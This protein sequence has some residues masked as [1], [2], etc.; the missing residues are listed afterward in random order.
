MKNTKKVLSV[1]LAGALAFGSMGAAFAAAPA[2]VQGTDYETAVERLSALDILKGYED[3]TFQ[4]EKTI[5]RAEFAAV[6]VRSLGLDAS[7]KSSMGTT[8][9]NDV[10]SNHWASGY[11][12]IASGLKVINGK[13]EGVFDPEAPVKYEEAVTM[14]VR[15]LGYEPAAK[16]KGGYPNG[17]LVIAGQEDISDDVKGTIGASAPRGIVAQL[18]DNSLEVPMMVQVGYGDDAKFVQS[19]TDGTDEETLLADK[20][21]TEK[22]EEKVIDIP[23]TDS[24]LDDNEIRLDDKGVIEVPEGF[25]FEGVYNAKIKAFINDDD[26]LVSYEVDEDTDIFFDAVE[27]TSGDEEPVKLVAKDKEY[28]F[29]KDATIYENGKKVKEADLNAKYSYAKAVV[30]D[31]KITSLEAYDLDNMIVVEKVEKTHVLGY[32][33]DVNFDDYYVIKD[34]KSIELSDLEEGDIVFYNTSAEYAEVFNKTVKG[35]ID[36]VFGAGFRLNDEDYDIASDSMYVDEDELETIDSDILDEMKEADKEVTVYLDRQDE[37]RLVLGDRGEVKTSTV[38]ALLTDDIDVDTD[39]RGNHTLL[40]DVINNS[41]KEISYKVEAKDVEIDIVKKWATD[42][43]N[44]AAVE[45]IAAVGAGNQH[46]VGASTVDKAWDKYSSDEQEAITKHYFDV[47]NVYGKVGEV[48][49]TTNGAAATKAL[50]GTVIE[51]KVDEDGDVTELNLDLDDKA[52]TGNI[53]TDAKYAEGE[54]LEKSSL[55]FDA[56]DGID[57]DDTDVS[58]W[59]KVGFETL[60]AG[61]V[62]YDEDGK[63]TYIAVTDSERDDEDVEDYAALITDVKKLSGD[64]D[65]WRIKAYV[66]GT[67]KTFYTDKSI[68]AASVSEGDVAMIYVDSKTGELVKGTTTGVDNTAADIDAMTAAETTEVVTDVKVSDKKLTVNGTEYRLAKDAYV[69][70]IEDTDDI[71]EISLSDLEEN[72]DEVTLVMDE[73]TSFVKYVL[74]TKDASE[75]ASTPETDLVPTTTFKS[76]SSADQADGTATVTATYDVNKGDEVTFKIYNNTNQLIAFKD[77]A[78]AAADAKAATADI[79][80]DEAADGTKVYTIKIVVNGKEVSERLVSITISGN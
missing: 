45:G 2:D 73:G 23:R 25:N 43:A 24:S 61:T 38:G 29:D 31:N 40:V 67:E 48:V 74:L 16:A 76:V 9:F 41:G 47:A 1:A 52:V 36:K 78:A 17:Y 4:P 14:I 72:K 46:A 53:K 37:V 18:M 68:T 15:A 71:E 20:L 5:T 10:P 65:E 19:G 56:T 59:E 70:D 11:I 39:A 30:V 63:I 55:V 62:Y 69:F 8:G 66:D 80:V 42:V 50:K 6:I 75:K 3:G 79:T 28:E 54:K 60:K 32:E 34:G 57:E 12:N 33:D 44:K 51:I 64:D 21:D 26:E 77:V 58:T 49:V 13:A 7:A 22:V 35:K 27:Y